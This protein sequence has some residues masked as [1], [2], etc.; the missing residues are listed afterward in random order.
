MR[1][2]LSLTALLALACT[3]PAPTTTRYLLP[4]D[5]S[6]GTAHIVPSI[7]VG[8]GRVSV[9][10]Y[11]SGPG[12]V[13]ETEVGQVRPARHHLWAEPLDTGLRR[14]LRIEISNALGHDIGGDPSQG[15][16]WRTTIDVHIDRLHGNLEGQARLV[17]RWRISPKDGPPADYRF[18]GSEAL[19]RPGYP[20]LVDAEVV[21]LR[22]LSRAIAASLPGSGG[23]PGGS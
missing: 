1:T 12:L 14:F 17:A 2:L 3:S 6:E 21:L 8:L 4:A 15:S 16:A 5:V 18:S 23:T 19:P 13:V 7:R 11:L 22:Q 9:P 10:P 20:G